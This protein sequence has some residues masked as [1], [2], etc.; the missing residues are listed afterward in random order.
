M[1]DPIATATDVRSRLNLPDKDTTVGDTTG[2]SDP[3][4]QPYLEDAADANAR[5]NDVGSMDDGVRKQIEW[6]LAGLKILSYR[7]GLRA[8]QQKSIGS[9]SRSYE[10]KSIVELRN[11]LNKWD[12]SGNLASEFKENASIDV[13]NVK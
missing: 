2:I 12:P 5:E 13:P 9:S 10:T 8:E 7:K 3:E 4:I 11:E 6:R 1:A